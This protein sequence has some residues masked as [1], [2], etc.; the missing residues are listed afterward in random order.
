[1]AK[2][3]GEVWLWRLL[4]LCFVG[5]LAVQI[6]SQNRFMVLISL[7]VAAVVGV[8]VVRH[9]RSQGASTRIDA[10]ASATPTVKSD[11][12]SSMTSEFYST[13]LGEP[14]EKAFPIPKP[15]STFGKVAWIKPGEPI[16]VAGL[17]LPGGM[18]Y[19]GDRI[20]RAKFSEP[21][22]I[23]LSLKVAVTTVSPS[24]MQDAYW[25]WYAEIT[26]LDRRCYLQWLADGRS[27][28]TANIGYVFLFFYGLERRALIDAKKDV[29]AQQELPAI[30]QEVRRLLGVYGYDNAFRGYALRFL[31]HLALTR[32]LSKLHESE[33]DTSPNFSGELPLSIRIALGQMAV[34]RQPLNAHWALAWA[35]TDP[36]ISRKTA[37]KRC[38]D[39]FSIV[40]KE[41]FDKRY[42][43]GITLPNNKTRLFAFYRPASNGLS[44]Q[45][46]DVGDLPDITA[47][48][49]TRNKLQ[50]VVDQC[51]A[52]LDP[53]SRYLG[54]NPHKE[55]A[56]EASLLL[57]PSLWS[58]DA[59]T[60]L[61]LLRAEVGEQPLILSLADLLARFTC[62]G[63]NRDQ[64]CAFAGTL[65]SL[66]VG[67]EPDVLSGAKTP[68]P[69]DSIVLFA[70]GENEGDL[71]ADDAFHAAV[72]TLD[73][74]SAVAAADGEASSEG[75]QLLTTHIDSWTQLSKA[76]RRRLKARLGLQL[77][78]PPTLA[79]LKKKL[80]PLGRESKGK[81]A[82][83]LAHLAQ[84]DG[85]VTPQ[86]VKLLERVYKV[87]GLDPQS[88]Y[89]DLHAAASAAPKGVP[90][91][92]LAGTPDPATH[93]TQAVVAGGTT[94]SD[95]SLDMSKITQLQRETAEVSALLAN[96]FVDDGPIEPV[97]DQ[98]PEPADAGGSDATLY[99]LDIDHS[100]FLRLLVSRSE[101][102]RAELEDVASDMDLML[103]GALERINDMA[104]D[105]FD[106]PISEGDDPIEINPDVLEELSL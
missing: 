92:A 23:D 75:A 17:T 62:E 102:S 40:F 18:L 47:T 103:D 73:L 55:G 1:M 56:F 30:E 69:G 36:N 82:G 85:V 97:V 90:A 46:I 59:Q 100:A 89:S 19:V 81:L 54:R 63:V 86:E 77:L 16:T 27:E 94:N 37:V 13:R 41:E 15:P 91:F 10:A 12:D 76:Q 52:L 53:Y 42:R 67:F 84:V 88:L 14:S 33:P 64:L 38:K 24:V 80:E 96:V 25:P 106:M 83:F 105:R 4:T 61:G 11:G 34:A 79:S 6:T 99:D 45:K 7:A 60:A 35:L 22:L 87:L 95:F 5:A 26:S 51:V 29:T 71:R 104:F 74:A 98:A 43:K 9:K 2:D 39:L 68:R 101:W 66:H 65:E 57:P 93:A 32:D 49:V 58:A 70:L 20:K 72:V 21:S 28:P 3:R 31:D 48:S 44:Q 50:A 8:L 78:Q